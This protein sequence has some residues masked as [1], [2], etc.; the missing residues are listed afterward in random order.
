[1]TILALRCI[2]KDHRH[3]NLQHSIRRPSISLARQQQ[4]D[5]G[6][7]NLFNT[8]LTM[9]ALQDVSEANSHWNK[10]AAINYMESKQDP[11]GAFTDPGLT[12]DV[13]L[14]LN[15]RGLGAIRNLDCDKSDPD[16]D[17]HSEFCINQ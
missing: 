16:F 4:P 1:M 13:L 7:G 9:Q 14:A 10:T 15:Q 17:N 2:V 12:A 5:G 11:D 3:R 6:F 8:A